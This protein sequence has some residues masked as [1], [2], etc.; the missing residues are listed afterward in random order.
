MQQS[1]PI[2]LVVYLFYKLN[3]NFVSHIDIRYV[4]IRGE[5][6]VHLNFFCSL[7]V[8]MY[9]SNFTSTQDTTP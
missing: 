4:Y 1:V 7:S 5:K 9:K 6:N 3:T 2:T 8:G